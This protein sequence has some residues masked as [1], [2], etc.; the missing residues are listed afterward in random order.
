[1]VLAI[2][3]SACAGDDK[4]KA[5]RGDEAGEAGQSSVNSGGSSASAGAPGEEGGTSAQTEGGTATSGAAPP[6]EGGA[7]A[8]GEGGA[9]MQTEGG[10]A[11]GTP[12]TIN[13]IVVASN[14]QPVPGIKVEVQGQSVTTG[15]DGTFSF[16][17]TAPY[18]LVVRGE[19]IGQEDTEAYL[20]L[21]R[22]DPKLYR[23]FVDEDRQGGISGV[24]S[25]GGG[26]PVAANHRVLLTF[27]GPV[28]ATFMNTLNVGASG[29]YNS[30]G[31][32]YWLTT[33]SLTGYLF[34]IETDV[35]TGA[36]FASGSKQVTLVDGDTVGS[37]EG[38]L[39]LTTPQLKSF[40]VTL[41]KPAAA[42]LSNFFLSLGGHNLQ[43]TLPTGDVTAQVPNDL[44]DEV[45][46]GVV[47][48]AT[49]GESS[50]RSTYRAPGSADSVELEWTTAP[51]IGSPAPNAELG[52]NA[53]F[54]YVKP[55][56]TVAVLRLGY[57]EFDPQ[58]EF[59]MSY[60]TT[61]FTDASSVTLARLV[62]LNLN[63]PP[64]QQLDFSIAT[65][66]V[67]P[68]IDEYVA[69]DRDLV[70]EVSASAPS[71]AFRRAF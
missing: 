16:E 23:S 49:E 67:E 51:V 38:D 21:T 31:D 64:G 9:P 62:G 12:I 63:L 57:S 35:T 24:L 20:G 48:Y 71:R 28:L 34:A 13:G 11:S 42:T 25:G 44:P 59:E 2:A 26:F 69:P 32:P 27:A 1:L 52:A 60:Y 29:T 56:N 41:N 15:S 10:A 22:P 46:I 36:I 54:T 40:G 61:V 68:T 30:S 6:T 53:S 39:V 4:K 43:P 3:F 14:E 5:A 70:R 50:L 33:P 55:A 8:T 37:P 7:S 47:A 58:T 66:A 18:D 19:I 65:D 17:A 45:T